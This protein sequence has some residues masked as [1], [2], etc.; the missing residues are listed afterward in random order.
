M[1]GRPELRSAL[2]GRDTPR[3]LLVLGL[4]VGLG[5]Y[6]HDA[7]ARSPAL[8]DAVDGRLYIP[9]LIV[10]VVGGA[11]A[12]SNASWN[13]G[14]VPSWLLVFAPVLG[15]L[16]HP[17]VQGPVSFDRVIVPV[18]FA[19][20]AALVVGT[21]GYVIGRRWAGRAARAGTAEPPEWLL[22]VLLGRDT[23]RTRLWVLV[24]FALFVI[25]G[26]VIAVTRPFLSL[27]VEGV[28]LIELFH[29][30][31][32]VASDTLLGSVVLLGWLGLAM[33]PAYRDAGLL[34]SWGLLFG[35]MF[36][37]ISADF[38]LGGISGSGPL[39]DATLAFLAA[40]IYSLVFGTGGFL[41]GSGLRRMVTWRRDGRGGPDAST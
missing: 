40:L 24:A 28:E 1:S 11:I 27:P 21:L 38:V 20:L 3:S 5:L 36:G 7:I 9:I 39:M 17:F 37:A 10:V 2:L 25:S 22:G 16:W 31:G 35:P 4:A 19:T 34:V 14:V 29:P 13:D 12:A 32:V 30:T 8:L 15:W 18:A 41:F 23:D 26:A 33:W 6:V